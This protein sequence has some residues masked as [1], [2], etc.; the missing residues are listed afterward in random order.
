[1]KSLMVIVLLLV[2]EALLAMPA[3]VL[4]MRHGE[5]PYPDEGI[6]LSPRGEARANSLPQLLDSDKHIEFNGLTPH[7]LYAMRPAKKKGSMR[8]IETFLPL[9]KKLNLNLQVQYSK[10][11]ISQLIQEIRQNKKYDGQTIWICWGHDELDNLVEELVGNGF[12]VKKWDSKKF[13][14]VWSV[15]FDSQGNFAA[16]KTISQRLL[17]GDTP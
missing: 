5:E 8:S 16:F 14:L 4:L 9:S 2:S 3:H 6:H 10:G 13:D 11:E 1:M 12:K 7:V 17:K 15:S